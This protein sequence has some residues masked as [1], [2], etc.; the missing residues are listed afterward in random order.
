MRLEQLFRGQAKMQF[1]GG[2]DLHAV[3]VK[4]NRDSAAAAGVI[5]VHEGIR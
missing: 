1:S 5:A 2:N 4:G 3:I